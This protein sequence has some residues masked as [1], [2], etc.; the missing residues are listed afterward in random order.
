MP[1]A[2]HTPPQI[3]PSSDA[4]DGTDKPKDGV[5]KDKAAEA[6]QVTDGNLNLVLTDRQDR[7]RHQCR[8]QTD[9]GQAY[10]R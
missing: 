3:Q 2:E 4:Q 7:R 6:E 5:L 9:D 10:F 1:Y 8:I